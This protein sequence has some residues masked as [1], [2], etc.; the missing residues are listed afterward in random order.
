VTEYRQVDHGFIAKIAKIL[1]TSYGLWLPA[2]IQG[3]P[4]PSG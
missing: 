1:Q 4:R 2:E 3:R